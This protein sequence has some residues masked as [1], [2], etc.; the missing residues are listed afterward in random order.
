MNQTKRGPMQVETYEVEEHTTEGRDPFEIEAEAQAI[1]EE[2]GLEGQRALMKDDEDGDVAT[3]TRVPYRQMT[4]E[5][6]RVYGVL[7]P[8]K[9][10]VSEY[11]AGPIPLRV[12]QVVAHAK[13][14][15]KRLEVWGPQTKDPDPVL[16]GVLAQK[17]SWGETD[18]LYL[19]ARW[20]DALE[21]FETLYARAEK[22]LTEKWTANAQEV[23]A[24]CRA[25]VEAPG[26][27]VKKHLSGEWTNE[28]WA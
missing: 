23:I 25:F 7:Y 11:G 6:V 18:V 2:L 9:A 1:I 13:P 22:H 26:A 10:N 24:K 21:P 8:E 28:P 20:G 19:L 15:F 5:E 27:C 14:L 3:K 16:V 17:Q 4:R 12:L